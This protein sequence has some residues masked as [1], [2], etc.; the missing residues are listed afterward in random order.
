MNTRKKC[1]L[2]G[3]VLDNC[4]FKS[5]EPKEGKSNKKERSTKP[6]NLSSSVVKYSVEKSEKSDEKDSSV[7][8]DASFLPTTTNP[9]SIGSDNISVPYSYDTMNTAN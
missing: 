1:E 3:D 4:S 5:P 7:S 8:E 6:I 2:A 9:T